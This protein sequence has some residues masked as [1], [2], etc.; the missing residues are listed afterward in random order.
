[1]EQ[2]LCKKCRRP[3][4]EGYKHKY[5]EHCRNERVQRFKNGCKGALGLVVIVGGTAVSILSKGNI[6]LGNINLNKK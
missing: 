2:K 1:M 6:N 3:L 5:C 4:P